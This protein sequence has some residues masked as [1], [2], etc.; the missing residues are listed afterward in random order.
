[1]GAKW[2]NVYWT[3]KNG[4]KIGTNTLYALSKKSLCGVLAMDQNVLYDGNKDYC[5]KCTNGNIIYVLNHD[6]YTPKSLLTI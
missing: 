2:Y 5:I 3:D 1:M 4:K 6:I